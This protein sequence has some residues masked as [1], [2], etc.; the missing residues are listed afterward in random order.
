[1]SLIRS[2]ILSPAFACISAHATPFAYVPNEKSASVSVIDTASGKAVRQIAA[3][4][5]GTRLYL[6]DA[7]GDALLVLDAASGDP[8][9]TVPSAA[10]PSGAVPRGRARGCACTGRAGRGRPCGSGR[11]ARRR[12]GRTGS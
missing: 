11:T 1:M 9:A 7:A 4:P 12:T 6:T 8:V 2:S 5:A 3:V 10:H